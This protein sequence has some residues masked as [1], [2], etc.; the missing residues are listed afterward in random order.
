[1]DLAES[2]HNRVGI[3]VFVDLI[4]DLVDCEGAAPL[5][6]AVGEY[7]VEVDLGVVGLQRCLDGLQHCLVELVLQLDYVGLLGQ[8]EIQLLSVFEVNVEVGKDK[9]LI[10]LFF[11][12]RNDLIEG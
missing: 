7:R 8:R 9:K 6:R 10:F 5:E 4:F 1:V 12:H 11:A 2:A 3:D